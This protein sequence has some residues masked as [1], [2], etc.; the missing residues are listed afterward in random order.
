[1]DFSTELYREHLEE[2][3]FLYGQ[4]G[5]LFKEPD[6]TWTD[7]G[8]FEQRLALHIEALV[9]GGETALQVCRRQ[10]NEGDAGELHAAVRVF[11]QHKRLDLMR[12]VFDALDVEDTERV[13]AAANGLKNQW[14]PEW[15]GEIAAL[16]KDKPQACA[17]LL[18]RVIGF[19]RLATMDQVLIAALTNASANQLY[20]LIWALGRIKAQ[21]A[22]HVLTPLL[23]HEETSIASAAALSLLRMGAAVAMDAA[24]M[25]CAPADFRH[26]LHLSLAG[27]SKD[28]PH[29][30]EQLGDPE[31]AADP[32]LALGLLGDIR[33]VE[34][35]LNLVGHPAAGE[36]AA[37]A[38][39]LITGADLY[40]EVFVP[41]EID[42]RAL[43]EEELEKLNRGEPL[44][45]PG[46][47]PGSMVTKLTQVPD[48]WRTWW[49]QN[50]YR[51]KVE[52]RYRNGRP[53]TPECLLENLKHEHSPFFLRQIAYEELVARYSLDIPF[54]TDM[55]VQDQ[56]IALQQLETQLHQTQNRWQPGAWYLAG[57]SM[58]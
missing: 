43:F 20:T 21:A 28:V 38:L 4:R 32:A 56:L 2:A 18:P 22:I 24:A 50:R 31:C 55:T 51:F 11:C 46:Q 5:V 41:E 49:G 15:T 54:E 6:V 40:Q 27:G 17:A 7:L 48:A 33:A 26:L 52:A 12:E 19:K 34:P 16:W 23:R 14:P 53:F 29:L 44:Y 25:Q 3:A 8:D 13:L 42:P 39:N 37:M 30:I 35:L 10:A 47:E 57:R 45:P 9:E 36:N 1:M 58:A